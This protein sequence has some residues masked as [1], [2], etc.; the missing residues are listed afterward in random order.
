M[1]VDLSTKAKFNAPNARVLESALKG[2]CHEIFD[3]LFFS[4][5]DYP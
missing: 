3:P 4:S 1:D 5:I 2:Q